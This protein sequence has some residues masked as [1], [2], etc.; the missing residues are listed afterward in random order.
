MYDHET[1]YRIDLEDYACPRFVSKP[2]AYLGTKEEIMNLMSH[3]SA[4]SYSAMRYAQTIE[5]VDRYDLDPD[6]THFVS[7]QE[8]PVL[9]P[10]EVLVEQSTVYVNI[11]WMHNCA[12]K[13]DISA[14]ASRLEVEQLLAL[15]GEQ[16]IRCAKFRFRDLAVC[17]PALGWVRLRGNFRGFPGVMKYSDS[18]CNYSTLFSEMEIYEGSDLHQAVKD[19]NRLKEFDYE[20]L[21]DDILGD[22]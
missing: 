9:T 2:K 18:G 15:A 16:L 13:A 7:G 21:L 12:S 20:I 17:M 19:T 22:M 11:T 14:K 6:A 4:N 8:R 3:L 10:V 5:A 1:I